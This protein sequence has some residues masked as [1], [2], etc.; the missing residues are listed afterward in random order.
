MRG[1]VG[2]LL[3]LLGCHA[4]TAADLPALTFKDIRLT[5]HLGGPK[6]EFKS[7]AGKPVLLT[8]WATTAKTTGPALPK[9]AELSKDAALFGVE[10]FAA[11]S[12]LSNPEVPAA[13]AR[14]AGLE[15]PLYSANIRVKGVSTKNG[16]LVIVLNAEGK[17][18]VYG[19]LPNVENDV[20]AFYG[21]LLTTALGKTPT[22]KPVTAILDGLAKG[23]K[24]AEG[25]AKLLPLQT[26]ADA[27]VAEE[28]KAV[29]KV[30]AD[31]AE[32]ALKAAT[33]LKAEDP[34]LALERLQRIAVHFKGVPAA[35]QATL[36]VAEWKK[37]KA[38][39]LELKAVPQLEALRKLSA[40]LLMQPNADAK[41]E[42]FQKANAKA[43]AQIGDAIKAIKKAFPDT[44]AAKEAQEV[45]ETY[46][47]TLK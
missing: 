34:L 12:S 45:Q 47:L 39:A 11:N 46:G 13:L 15:V 6:T 35:T 42:Q 37:D 10:A 28:A 26:N 30:Y 36:Q 40:T 18:A 14:Q 44:A 25:L 3:I 1:A 17:C 20:Y 24:P 9:L 38:I 19:N 7:A 43:I 4:L 5:K 22:T 8:L 21:K 33:A 29:V 2:V 41:A 27:A 16:P 31:W 23:D 32:A